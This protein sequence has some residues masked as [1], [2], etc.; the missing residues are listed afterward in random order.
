MPL[1]STKGELRILT[2]GE[3]NKAVT[4]LPSPVLDEFAACYIH[5]SAKDTP[6]LVLSD[7]RVQVADVASLHE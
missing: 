5:Y 6:Q 3:V 7:S 1:E 4:V 2:S